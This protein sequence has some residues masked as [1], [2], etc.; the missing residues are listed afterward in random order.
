MPAGPYGSVQWLK[1]DL[2]FHLAVTQATGNPYMTQFLAFVS[3]RVRE[4]ILAAGGGSQGSDE[5]AKATLAEHKSILAAIEIGDV[6]AAHDAMRLHLDNA[7]QRLGLP[8]DRREKSTKTSLPR[9]RLEE[10]P[11]LP[12]VDR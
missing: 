9:K 7:S 11:A 8:I 10:T 12:G 2:E 5:M 4:S 1:G 3:E 6:T